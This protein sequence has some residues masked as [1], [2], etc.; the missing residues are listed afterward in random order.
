MAEARGERSAAEI[1]EEIVGEVA[2]YGVAYKSPGGAGQLNHVALA[3]ATETGSADTL[4]ALLDSQVCIGVFGKH[5]ST[6]QMLNRIVRRASARELAGFLMPIYVYVRSEN[7]PADTPSRTAS[8]RRQIK[9]V[10]K[11]A[12]KE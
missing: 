4:R 8:A 7:N 12:A 6:T 11:N 10:K 9:K 5:R 1:A 3:V 2:T